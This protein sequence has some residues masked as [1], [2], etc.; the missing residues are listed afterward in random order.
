MFD[1]TNYLFNDLLGHAYAVSSAYTLRTASNLPC[2]YHRQIMALVTLL[3]VANVG[4]TQTKHSIINS[5]P[6]TVITPR[7]TETKQSNQDGT[8]T[9][10][11]QLGAEKPLSE[12]YT[13]RH[14]K[15]LLALR[16]IGRTRG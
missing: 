8:P 10:S 6:N 1:A 9:G 12:R 15:K 16:N 13:L 11:K 7:K 4:T 14:V 2:C 5:L 3:G